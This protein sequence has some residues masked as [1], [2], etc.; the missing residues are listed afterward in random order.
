MCKATTTEAKPKRNFDHGILTA[1]SHSG[2]LT[3][4][5]LQAEYRA[6]RKQYICA[7]WT[8]DSSVKR[9]DS[10]IFSQTNKVV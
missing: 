2:S 8:E 3:S 1:I 4:V 10:D 9:M 7:D 5:E 6:E